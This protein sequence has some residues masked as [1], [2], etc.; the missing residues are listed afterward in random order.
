MI[1]IGSHVSMSAPDYL[2]GSVKEALSYGANAMMV[3]TGPPQNTRRKDISE[4]KVE[5]AKTLLLS[6]NIEI[7]DCIVH[8]PYI[9]NLANCTKP[10]TFELAVS[11]L[12]K[13]I[14]RVNEIGFST[15]VLHPGSH[16]GAGE[17][18]GL[19]RIVLG[20]NEAMKNIGDVNIAIET[21][22]GKGSELG[23]RFEHIK[24]IIDHVDKPDHIKVCMDTCHIHDAGYCINK[25]DELL[26]EFDKII[27]LDS[28]VC[29]HLNDSKNERGDK[30]DRH[31]NIGFGK[32][33]FQVLYDIVHHP[34]L[35]HV[36]KILETPY[37]EGYPPYKKEINMLLNHEFNENL[38][39]EIVKESNQ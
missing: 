8:A 37:I 32:I 23:Y 25:F 7:K 18:A 22:S 2:L 15:L 10:D 26:E 14:E 13:E 36:V 21:M 24:Y 30:K 19:D 39:N 9:I 38:H 12:K 28:L 17:E 20:L 6:S 5:E 35:Q 11:F 4:L 1:K 34:K 31:E 27:G 16:V 33:G 29:I 3:Y